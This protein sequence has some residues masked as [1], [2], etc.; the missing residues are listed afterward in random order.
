MADRYEIAL[1]FI[2]PSITK[3][4]PPTT[5]I[6]KIQKYIQY[7]HD[8]NFI[9]LANNIIETYLEMA[10][11]KICKQQKINLIVSTQVLR[12]TLS[13][14]YSFRNIYLYSD[15]QDLSYAIFYNCNPMKNIGIYCRIL[16]S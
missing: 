13:M 4:F 14:A 1:G 5:S 16:T 8:N 11:I 15:L 12:N 2:E 10:I 6:L 9:F 3:I 7:C